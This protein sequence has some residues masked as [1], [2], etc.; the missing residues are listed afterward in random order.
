MSILRQISTT[1]L[2]AL[3]GAVLAIAAGG[4]AIASALGGGGPI[5]PSKSLAKAIH[6]AL[7][8]PPVQ[9]ITAR[10]QFTNHLIDSSSLQRACMEIR[11]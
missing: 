10:I 9:G 6:D 2:L 11:C 8:A 4:T 5:P 7:A 3:C 1:R